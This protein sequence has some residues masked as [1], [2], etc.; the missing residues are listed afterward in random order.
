MSRS[1]C[2]VTGTR[3]E[4]G[5]LRWVME[6]I[7][8]SADLVLRVVATGMHLS[9]EFGMTVEAMEADG[10]AVD[11]RVEM[12]INSDT[13]SAVTK[14]MGLGLIGFAD[15][16]RDLEPDI[17]VILGDRFEA[18]AA[19]TAATVAQ[20][21]IAHL[22]GGEVTE[23]VID[24][25]FRHSITKMAHLH[26][27]AAAPYR[28]RV[29]QLGEEQN[30]VFVV[31]GLG[32]DNLERLELMNRPELADSLG[33]RFRERN[34][35]V[36]FHPVTRE[37]LESS[38]QF[39]ELL[40][41]LDCL[42]DTGLIFTLPNADVGGRGLATMA[43]KFT[44]DRS[45]ATVFESLGQVRYL[46]CLREADGVVGNSSSGL[47]EAPSLGTGT[48]D[49]GSRQWGR[50]RAP[51]V[52]SCAPD[53]DQIASAIDRLFSVEFRD[54]ARK[55]ESPYGRAGASAQVVEILSSVSLDGILRKRFV[56]HPMTT[57]S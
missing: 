10:F 57:S 37:P 14:S 36:T 56:D 20:I 11:H 52:I 8:S 39:S 47:L 6:D 15:V 34:L 49:I 46:S 53:R 4:Y 19:A 21:P 55:Q 35:L 3:A 42:D 22:H 23:G 13:P 40:L 38:E 48:V 2:V 26:F 25:A 18:L 29:L 44:N 54:V 51:S 5:L 27:V 43:R 33:F 24:E 45:S 41:A 31:G 28:N 7:R 50:L 1:V 30:R 12:L 32:L 16:F 9:P 17:I